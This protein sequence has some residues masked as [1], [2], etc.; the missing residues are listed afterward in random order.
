MPNELKPC[1]FCGSDKIL[2]VL[3]HTECVISCNECEA[4]ISRGLFCGKCNTLN[5]ADEMFGK[6]TNDAWNRRADNVQNT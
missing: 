5:E 1:P 6:E 2:R 4:Q 3:T